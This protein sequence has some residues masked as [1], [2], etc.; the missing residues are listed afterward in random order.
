MSAL[1]ALQRQEGEKEEL[2]R[3]LLLYAMQ[4]PAKRSFRA[5]SRANGKSDSTIRSWSSAR[6]WDERLVGEGTEVEIAAIRLFQANYARQKA[7]VRRIKE[8]MRVSFDAVIAGDLGASLSPDALMAAT[9]KKIEAPPEEDEADPENEGTEA[10]RRRRMNAVIDD[11]LAGLAEQLKRKRLK[12]KPSDVGH[13]LKLMKE[14][15]RMR[16]PVGGPAEEVSTAHLS[17][18][19]KQSVGKSGDDLL[20]AIE[21]DAGEI[22]LLA[23]VMREHEAVDYVLPVDPQAIADEDA[24]AEEIARA[25]A[26]G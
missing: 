11:A 16:E 26:G 19:V 8:F 15:E 24:A 14:L 13:I 22:M 7:E 21:A 9:R 18:R 3:G 23:R 20:A 6:R 10:R 4:D 25:L 5:V 12:M 1:V 2:H 17:E